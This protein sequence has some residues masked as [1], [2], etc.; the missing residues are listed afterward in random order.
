[1]TCSARVAIQSTPLAENP[2]DAKSL[3]VSDPES[4]TPFLLGDPS[5]VTTEALADRFG[6]GTMVGRYLILRPLGFGGMGVVLL[7]DDPE[8][9]RKVALKLLRPETA[10]D[11]DP[12]QSAARLLHEAQ[13]IAKLSHPNVVSVFDVGP[14][15]D[16]VFVAM[17]YVDGE[18]LR[19]W[20]DREP[21]SADAILDVFAPAGAGIGAAHAAGMV[22]RDVK[23]SNIQL[24][25]DG[26][27][28]VLDFGLARALDEAPP[29]PSKSSE[30]S[31]DPLL[32]TLRYM[33]PELF[34]GKPATAKADQYAFCVALFEALYGAKP[35]P[36]TAPDRWRNGD[37]VSISPNSGGHRGH[38]AA[39]RPIVVKGLSP[40]PGDR[41]KNIS[42]L[43]A[44]LAVVRT[45][46]RR[47]A[48]YGGAAAL[49]AV[50]VT[51]GLAPGR[52]A[53]GP[54][55][56]VSDEMRA[57]WSVERQAQIRR[58]F[59]AT[60][61]SFATNAHTRASQGLEAYIATWI[62]ARTQ[63]CAATII[64]KT[65]TGALMDLRVACLQRRHQHVAALIE[66]FVVADA[67]TVQNAASAVSNLPDTD[68]C[69]DPIA[70]ADLPP[71][72][73]DPDARDDVEA[74]RGELAMLNTLRAAGQYALA[75][76]K[77]TTIEARVSALGYGP[78]SAEFHLA[79][80]R[81]AA[82]R[83][84]RDDAER[85]LRQ[86]VAD[87]GVTHYDRVHAEAWLDLAVELSREQKQF[88]AG[89][90][91]AWAGSARIAAMDDD[92]GLNARLRL[93]RA[94]LHAARGDTA[95]AVAIYRALLTE[96]APGIVR[97]DVLQSIGE[98]EDGPEGVTALREALAARERELGPKHPSVGTTL[99][100]LGKQLSLQGDHDAAL[101]MAEEA[102]ELL[103]ATF[104][105]SS[106]HVADAVSMKGYVE[107]R[108]GNSEAA[109]AHFEA[110][111][112]LMKASPDVVEFDL[113][114]TMGNLG[115]I[116][117]RLGRHP[118]SRVLQ[119]EAIEVF[120]RHDPD[121]PQIS[122][123]TL[124]VGATYMRE[125]NY[126]EAIIWYERA[127]VLLSKA[128]KDGRAADFSL[129]IAD[130][131]RMLGDFQRAHAVLRRAETTYAREIPDDSP[132][133]FRLWRTR[134]QVL[135]DEGR[136]ADAAAAAERAN[137]LVRGHPAKALPAGAY[138]EA[139]ILLAKARR[140][141]G[142]EA[143][144]I[145][146]AKLAAVEFAAASLPQEAQAARMFAQ[147]TR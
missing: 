55:D 87:S 89:E 41:Y 18:D 22:H 54:C 9:D 27:V 16:G 15:S 131:H 48:L 26:R 45:R 108:R 12:K 139:A 75:Q 125:E 146:A 53:E 84:R 121:H 8:L 33:A 49:L 51:I 20:I 10:L 111:V 36:K 34:Q 96:S 118:E 28:R 91:A 71:M 76:E 94:R 82:A 128:G 11:E 127:V 47:R 122:V 129:D 57:L 126:E 112:A 40:D 14:F 98:L 109:A 137:T 70:L 79:A 90:E 101:A 29:D 115:T 123:P 106:L 69:G 134:A 140:N 37:D 142:Q 73:S 144:A 67:T 72:P 58:A 5:V 113:A 102:R 2:Q 83:S 68:V 103:T 99:I 30:P 31:R 88:A 65:Q 25:H 7:A 46:R 60:D 66:T 120:R 132:A 93:V 92:H 50:G 19:A 52:D 6:R 116:Y 77:V 81:I 85:H 133:L 135:V 74:L 32:G 24:G 138:A 114:A 38:P 110:A 86:A 64:D 44:A 1:M 107:A 23:P 97:H 42:T 124:N 80:G 61:L 39:L 4:E 117:S 13:A 145:E 130:A 21:R 104:G 78:V 43:L 100:T 143:E 63:A 147:T 62:D 17:E 136:H 59:A 105:P 56:R 35:F 119:L 3:A 95:Q 141:A